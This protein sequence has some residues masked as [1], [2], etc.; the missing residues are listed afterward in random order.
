M[1]DASKKHGT[2]HE[3]RT[4]PRETIF[5]EYIINFGNGA[6]RSAATFM[7]GCDARTNR[8]NA[9]QVPQAMLNASNHR[10]PITPH[11]A[12]EKAWN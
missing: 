4:L 7:K 11:D 6:L 8:A 12:P 5:R 1:Y 9:R 10:S 2:T 3:K